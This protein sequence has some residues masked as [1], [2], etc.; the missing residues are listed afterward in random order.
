MR[1]IH[2]SRKPVRQAT[3]RGLGLVEL[4][5]GI[6]V[7]LIVAAGA[8]VV[9]TRQIDEHRRLMLEVQMQQDLRI[10]ADLLQ[11]ELRR[12]GYRGLAANGV[13]TPTANP[14]T[15]NEVPAK[16]AM[17][18][19]YASVTQTAKGGHD[20]FYAYAKPQLDANGLSKLNTTNVL[21]DNEQFGMQLSQDTLFIQLGVVNG[22]PNW[23]AIT[24]PNLVIVTDFSVE[25]VEQEVPLDD[26]CACPAGS[27]CPKQTVRRVD[28]TIK[29]HAKADANIKRTLQGSE[30]LRFDGISGACPS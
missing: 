3:Q 22:Q 14:G 16:D 6:T 13:W 30:K 27:V 17:S 7:G 25:V 24:D 12:A 15:A 26:L 9:A 20:I 8:A 29:A 19:P 2:L 23:Q 21:Q 11:Q 28:F 4:M 1:L 18:S 5:V 10:A